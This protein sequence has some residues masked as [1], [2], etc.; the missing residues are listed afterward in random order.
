MRTPTP[1]KR[2]V[3]AN[4]VNW[5][6][7]SVFM[8][9]GGATLWIASFKES[10]QNAASNVFKMGLTPTKQ[11]TLPLVGHGGMHPNPTGQFDMKISK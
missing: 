7:W 9:F 10:T 2:S 8:I 5:L 1:R 3:Q 6:L 11:R 4:D